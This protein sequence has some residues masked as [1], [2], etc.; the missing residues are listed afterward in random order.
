ML[1]ITAHNYVY[2]AMPTLITY[3]NIIHNMK[4]AGE[5]CHAHIMQSVYLE[6]SLVMM[7]AL[8]KYQ[9]CDWAF[10]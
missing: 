8:L 4:C 1:Y 2:L 10:S 5:V 3:T 7:I 9:S 6:H